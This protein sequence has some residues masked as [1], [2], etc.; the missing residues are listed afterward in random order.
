MRLAAE[1]LSRDL[2]LETPLEIRM[3][4]NTGWFVA[5]DVGGSIVRE[6]SV[7]GDAVN[8]A[9][10]LKDM[11]RVGGIHVGPLTWETT[12]EMFA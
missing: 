3:R 10:R 8:I 9:A 11:A 2:S 6:F 1:N 5:G 7:M 12:R 4:I